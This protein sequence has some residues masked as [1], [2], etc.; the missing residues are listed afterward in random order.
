[1]RFSTRLTFYFRIA[2][3]AVAM[4]LS[5]G[6][7]PAQAK[8]PVAGKVE[9]AAELPIR[10]GNVAVDDEGR[11]FATV[12]PF[13]GDKPVQLIEITD[14]KT[15]RA[16]PSEDY[17]SDGKNYSDE[18][19]DSPIGIYKDGQNRIWI[20]DMGLHIGK[21]RI[22]GFDTRSNALFK[23]IDL[24]ADIAPKGSFIQDLVVDD[25]SGWIYLADAANAALVAVEITTGKAHRFTGHPSLQVE[26]ETSLVADGK[27]IYRQGKPARIAVNPITLS[28]DG[29]TLF[30]GAMNGRTWYGV[31]ASLFRQQ[32]PDSEIAQAVFKVGAKPVSDGATTDA[33]GN[34]FFTNLGKRGIDVLTTDG[35][36][37]P[38]LRDKLLDWPDNVRFGPDS[39]LYI[40]V[41]QLHKAPAFNEGIDKGQPP[42]YIL[43]VKVGAPKPGK[44][45]Q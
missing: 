41:N 7:L 13:D 14:M 24:P 5:Y 40:A 18:R 27:T 15:F 1:M 28:A 45:K 10:P 33:N 36:L 35:Q 12:H 11:I 3:L 38:L 26:A 44:A 37:H 22:W 34:H 23:R 6:S 8:A 25:K 21:T 17:Q 42:Y 16:W 20:T 9:I 32:A 39:W 2:S 30:F 19:I 31:P 4:A 43:K 29:E